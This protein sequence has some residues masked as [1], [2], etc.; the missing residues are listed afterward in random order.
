MTR[1]VRVSIRSWPTER[2]RA[3]SGTCAHGSALSRACSVFWLPLTR[4]IG[5][6][7]TRA[8]LGGQL[9]GGEPGVGGDPRAGQ[10]A[11]VIQRGGQR[12][13]GREFTAPAGLRRAGD[14]PE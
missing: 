6:R 10:Q 13:R 3:A 2:T 5:V 9:P 14:L 7:A 12:L 1:M 11:T 8:Q 4:R